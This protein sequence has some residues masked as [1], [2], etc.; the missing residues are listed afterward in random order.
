MGG[1]H[2][3]HSSALKTAAAGETGPSLPAVTT[4]S[5]GVLKGHINSNISPPD[6][7]SSSFIAYRLSS[8]KASSRTS[9]KNNKKTHFGSNRTVLRSK[10]DYV[11]VWDQHL[12]V[13]GKE[14]Q[15]WTR[16][17]GSW[18]MTRGGRLQAGGH[19]CG[20]TAAHIQVSYSDAFVEHCSKVVR[21]PCT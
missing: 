2:V 18:R 5:F 3:D 11:D 4:R 13:I 15:R 19:S 10:C 8:V 21:S 12:R 9:R 14:Q 1:E 17:G 7:A 16:T 6:G 20:S